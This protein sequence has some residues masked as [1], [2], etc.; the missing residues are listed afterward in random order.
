MKRR[1]RQYAFVALL[2]GTAS[3]WAF[4]DQFRPSEIIT[5]ANVRVRD[6]DTISIG[7]A[8]IRLHGIDAPEY[9]QTCKDAA[10]R[11][12]PCGRVARTRLA[13]LVNAGS[14]RCTT[15]AIDRYHRRVARCA[16]T[17]VPDLSAALVAAGLAI[18][19]DDRGTARYADEQRVARAARRGVWQGAFDLPSTWRDTH[20]R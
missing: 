3:V 18:S 16:A 1:L 14:I 12:W 4:G 5:G 13:A 10:G 15:L 2:L 7:D 17:G 11:D 9:R 6:G 8:I 19:P 20:A